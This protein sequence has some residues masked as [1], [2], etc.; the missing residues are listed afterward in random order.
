[1]V[2]PA[3][4][5]PAEAL[6]PADVREHGSAPGCA[7][8]P[9]Q[10]QCIQM[11]NMGEHRQREIDLAKAVWRATLSRVDAVFLM[12]ACK[13]GVGKSTLSA[14]FA[15]YLAS[16]GLRVGVVDGD[17]CGPSQPALWGVTDQNVRVEDDKWLPVSVPMRIDAEGNEGDGLPPIKLLSSGCMTDSGEQAIAYGGDRKKGAWVV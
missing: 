2:P 3:P 17:V 11:A 8:C 6:C 12:L 4:D 15:G 13:G 16:L 1:M 9:Q 5:A 7:G 14:Q 10:Q